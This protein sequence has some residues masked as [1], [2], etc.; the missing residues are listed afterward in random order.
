MGDPRQ[1]RFHL[2]QQHLNVQNLSSGSHYG[3]PV[4]LQQAGGHVR[5]VPLGDGNGLIHVSDQLA[6][7]VV[8]LVEV[9]LV[10]IFPA[11]TAR[12]V[13]CAPGHFPVGQ[14]EGVFQVELH[15]VG[16]VDL[17]AEN[18][19]LHRQRVRTEAHGGG[20]GLG[21]DRSEHV[22]VAEA[23][24][25]LDGGVEQCVLGCNSIDT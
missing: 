14:A 20:D 4:T 24:K 12:D 11:K 22:A 7:N 1:G 9:R 18:V 8:K 10:V 19:G 5:H 17:I 13:I 3:I 25:V 2:L 23:P 16:E 15:R 21:R 6:L